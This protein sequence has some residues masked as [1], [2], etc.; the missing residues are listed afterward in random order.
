MNIHSIMD[1]AIESKASDI[2][3][4]CNRKPSLRIDGEIREIE[5]LNVLDEGWLFNQVKVICNESQLEILQKDRQLDFSVKHGEDRFRVHIFYQKQVPTIVMRLIN[6]KIPNLVDLHL[7]TSINKVLNIHDG[8]IIVTGVTG[9][10]KSTTLAS[11]IDYI[12]STESK[13]IITIEDPIEYVHKHKKSII[14]QRE[15]GQDVGSFSEAIRSAM[16][17]DPDILLV[18]EMRDLDTIQ[19]ALIMA[20]T[21]HLVFGTLHTKGCPETVDRM[22][23][24]FESN[25]QQIRVQVANSLRVVINQRLVPKVGGGRVPIVEIMFVNDAIRALIKEGSNINAIKDEMMMSSKVTGSQTIYQSV[26]DLLKRGLITQETALKNVD[27]VNMLK[28]FLR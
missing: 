8:M 5:S 20:E 11:I 10:G 9:S 21:G 25:Q 2:H 26:V 24:V 19:N 13:N 22:I 7:P 15:V 16:R 12:N 27:D 23:S 18:G 14:S 4:V 17:S 1:K 6:S 3:L 28:N